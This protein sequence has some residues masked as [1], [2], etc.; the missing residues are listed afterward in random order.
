MVLQSAQGM[1]G[2]GIAES[3]FTSADRVL[4]GT[5][6]EGTRRMLAAVLEAEVN[7]CIAEF[8][9]ERDGADRPG[10]AQRPPPTAQGHH[11]R[12]DHRGQ[13]AAGQRQ[14]RKRADAATGAWFSSSILP[15]WAR[16]SPRIGEVL[17]D[18]W[19]KDPYDCA[20]VVEDAELDASGR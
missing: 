16:K 1:P 12:R 4:N 2:A 11:T 9:D 14:A 19:L 18:G 15:P 17:P 7:A 13:G 10:R 5:F 6:R 20:G 3:T 8:A